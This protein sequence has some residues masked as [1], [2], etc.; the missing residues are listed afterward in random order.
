MKVKITEPILNYSVEPL[1]DRDEKGKDVPLTWRA[2]VFTALNSPARD[3]VLTAEQ[4]NQAYQ[5]TTK[6][7]A[8]SEPDLTVGE[9]AYILER[10]NKIIQSPLACGRAKEFF[11]EKESK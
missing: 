7:Y 11:E 10:I 2:L 5:I 6:V 4:K 1:L 3:E 9:R 8:S